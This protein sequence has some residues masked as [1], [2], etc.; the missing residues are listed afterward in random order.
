MPTART[1]APDASDS[2]KRNRGIRLR[3]KGMDPR[4]LIT[5]EFHRRKSGFAIY[6]IPRADVRKQQTPFFH[7]LMLSD[8]YSIISRIFK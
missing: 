2:L 1:T 6:G 5:S 3:R 7:A 8:T 4:G